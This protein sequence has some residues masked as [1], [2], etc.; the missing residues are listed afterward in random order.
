MYAFNEPKKFKHKAKEPTMTTTTAVTSNA[1]NAGPITVLA[2]GGSKT[3]GAASTV[4]FNTYLQ[5]LTAQLKNQDPLN[6]MEGTD[7]TAQLAQFSQLEQQINSN[8]YLEGLT[9]S[10][11]YSL[12]TLAT[13]YL[14]KDTLVAGNKVAKTDDSTDFGFKLDKPATRVGIDIFDSTGAKVRTLDVAGGA[15]SWHGTVK[16]TRAPS[17]QVAPTP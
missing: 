5:L 17:P 6:P 11:S 3:A 2:T 15:T 14:G 8:K 4:T 1:G 10:N 12:Q 13:S 7:F 9:K 16:P